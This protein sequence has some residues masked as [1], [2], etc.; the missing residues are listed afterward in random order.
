MKKISKLFIIFCLLISGC[1]YTTHSVL[2]GG[3]KTLYV[4]PVKNTM[5][6]AEESTEYTKYRS[7]PPLLEN[8]FTQSLI[9]RFHFDGN[10]KT[11]RD[12][13]ADLVL[14]CEIVDFVRDVLRYDTN[15]R[16]DEYR[17][18]MSF[19]YTLANAQDTSV[20]TKS[21]S[22]SVTYPLTGLYAKSESAALDE[23]LDDASRRIVESIVEEW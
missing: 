5:K 20:K 1:G 23:L 16:V 19:R 4:V 3:A 22:T 13:T 12:Q 2:K 7:I 14:N 17:L 15:D 21:L 9:E 11:V 6:M 18:K 10:V 8:M